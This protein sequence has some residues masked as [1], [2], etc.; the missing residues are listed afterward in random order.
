VA[1]AEERVARTAARASDW[2]R[3]ASEGVVVEE[4]GVVVVVALLVAVV[5]VRA[6]VEEGGVRVVGAEVVDVD[7][8]GDVVVI[9]WNSGSDS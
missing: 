9:F 1:P 4:G 2:A 6:E 7:V 3:L 5:V 8:E